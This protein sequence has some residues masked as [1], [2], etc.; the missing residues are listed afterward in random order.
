MIVVCMCVCEGVLL[1][2]DCNTSEGVGCASVDMADLSHN[3][4]QRR[5][6]EEKTGQITG[7][8]QVQEAVNTT[9]THTIHTRSRTLTHTLIIQCG[10]VHMC[11]PIIARYISL[12]LSDLC[13][14][15]PHI[16]CAH[17]CAVRC[18]IASHNH[19]HN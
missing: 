13:D 5:L 1:V 9:H 11:G 16:V 14:G 10:I 17:M 8:Q 3:E 6:Q 18:P 15:G 2:L 7:K 12:Y 19:T 4:V